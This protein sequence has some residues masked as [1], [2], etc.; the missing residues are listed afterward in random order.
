M[1]DQPIF[2]LGF[3]KRFFYLTLGQ[4]KSALNITLPNKTEYNKPASMYNAA[5][6]FLGEKVE[7]RYILGGVYWMDVPG[8]NPAGVKAPE[9]LFLNKMA[10]RV[11]V[12]ACETFRKTMFHHFISRYLR[13]VVNICLLN[14][15]IFNQETLE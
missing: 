4:A 13:I 9:K 15:F 12:N 3:T 1:P 5:W 10:S 8:S 2:V 6:N 11:R 7:K 14:T